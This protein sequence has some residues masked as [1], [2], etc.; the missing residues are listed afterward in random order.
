[1]T[2]ER[3]ES[4]RG[5]SLPEYEF[6]DAMR[7]AARRKLNAPP[8]WEWFRASVL[9]PY[10]HGVTLLHGGIPARRNDGTPRV[11]KARWTGVAVQ[12]CV[13]TRE[14]MAFEMSEYER[15]TGR[16]ADCAGKGERVSGAG[17]RDGETYRTWK[18]CCKCGGSG[19]PSSV[20]LAVD[21]S[22]STPAPAVQQSLFLHGASNG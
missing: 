9:K 6:V 17:V 2:T 19:V 15:T 16:C 14:E 21:P 4:T 3:T 7:L 1:M 10:A 11:G 5:E 13:V 22:W 8:E 20:V 12:E 18:Q